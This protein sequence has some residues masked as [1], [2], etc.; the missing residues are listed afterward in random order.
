VRGAAAAAIAAALLAASGC[1]YRLVGQGSGV[2]P[3][4]VKVVAIR[5]FENR[6]TRPEIEQRITEEVAREFSRRGDYRVVTDAEGADALLEGAVTDLRTNPV[7]FNQ[8]GRA[9]RVETVVL[10]Q[11]TLRDLRTDQVLWQQANLPFREQF[12]VPE[13]ATDLTDTETLALEEIARGAADALVSS[14]LEGF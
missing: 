7:Q 9:T 13:T 14:I 6:T 10:V 11:A 2:L 4:T 1:G 8:E 3:S 12:D 5:T